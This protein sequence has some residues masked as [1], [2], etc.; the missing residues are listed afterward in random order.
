MM[1]AAFYGS[2][3]TKY[4]SSLRAAISLYPVLYLLNVSS[5][6]W[7]YYF[8][9]VIPVSLVIDDLDLYKTSNMSGEISGLFSSLLVM[10]SR[11]SAALCSLIA[12]KTK[13]VSVNILGLSG[14]FFS[15]VYRNTWKYRVIDMETGPFSP[16]LDVSYHSERCN[17]QLHSFN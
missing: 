1:T 17:C 3:W 16:L 9:I 5:T 6:F 11:L 7:M 4:L 15:N 12:G 10:Y 8:E 2:I 14:W 13:R